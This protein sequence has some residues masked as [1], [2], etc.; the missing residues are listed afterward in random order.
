ML[1][2]LKQ[3]LAVELLEL[4]FDLAVQLYDIVC[5][6][7]LLCLCYVMYAAKP[8]LRGLLQ[9]FTCFSTEFGDS[10]GKKHYK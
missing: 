9:R 4:Y 1:Q 3:E 6:L 5:A 7:I 8:E 2:W 10:Q